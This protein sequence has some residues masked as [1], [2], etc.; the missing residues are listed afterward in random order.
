M[1][2]TGQYV[3]KIEVL[4]SEKRQRKI[5]GACM[6]SCSVVSNSL[7]PH[8]LEPTRP[9]CPWDSPGKS[10]GVGCHVLL[11]IMNEGHPNLSQGR[12]RLPERDDPE[13]SLKP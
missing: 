1:M 5:D 12:R 13:L 11:R 10:T 2:L 8:G 4:I 3:D 7:Q 9:L 6:L